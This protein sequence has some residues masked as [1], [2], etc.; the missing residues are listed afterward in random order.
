[1]WFCELD[2]VAVACWYGFRFGG[3]ESHFQSGRD[4]RFERESPGTVLLVQT[5]RAAL[6]DGVGEYRFLRGGEAY[7]GRF[8]TDDP[9]LETVGIARTPGGR[10]ALAAART[11]DAVGLGRW[12]R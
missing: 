7:K 1:M 11:V 3:V 8:A 10:L 2:G 6:D 9:G 12:M 5:I 4:P